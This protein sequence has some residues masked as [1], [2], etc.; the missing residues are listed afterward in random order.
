M[1][2][3]VSLVAACGALASQ[4]LAQS[5]PTPQVVA[6]FYGP[7]PTGVSVSHKGRVFVNFPRWGDK[8]PYTVA[9]VKNG[10]TVPYPDLAHNQPDQRDIFNHLISVQSIMVDPKDRLW[11][12]DTGSIKFGPTRYGGPK[13]L[14]VNLATN[15]VFKAIYF[16]RTVVPSTSYLNDVRF[17]LQRGTGGM[18]FITDSGEHGPNGIVVVDLA[19]G[20]SWRRLAFDPSVRGEPRFLPIVE[21]Q[22]LKNRP[23][24]APTSYLKL[25]S[26]GIAMSQDGRRLFYCP[27]SSRRLYSVSID[28]LLDQKRTNA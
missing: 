12:L 21:G 27:L 15:K 25:G 6:S 24:N 3:L 5:T 4:A 28:A 11:I 22:P 20:K 26:D 2:R 9:E 8:V 1:H 10:K 23:K 7:M 14:G 13:L 19:T 17:D 16:P 18:A